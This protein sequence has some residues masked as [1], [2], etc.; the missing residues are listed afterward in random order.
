MPSCFTQPSL[1]P[2]GMQGEVTALTRA[3]QRRPAGSHLSDSAECDLVQITQWQRLTSRGLRTPTCSSLT[4]LSRE[5]NEML[6][7]MLRAGRWVAP[8]CEPVFL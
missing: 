3:R 7:E 4:R 2:Q 6:D 5:S 8:R 1:K